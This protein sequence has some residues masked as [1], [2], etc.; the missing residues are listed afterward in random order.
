MALIGQIVEPLVE[1]DIA[2]PA[3]IKLLSMFVDDFAQCRMSLAIANSHRL[4][5]LA[6]QV[7]PDSH[8]GIHEQAIV[9]L[10]VVRQGQRDRVAA[11]FENLHMQ[12]AI[13]DYTGSKTAVQAIEFGQQ[14]EQPQVVAFVKRHEAHEAA[15]LRDRLWNQVR[16]KQHAVTIAV[17]EPENQG[18]T[19]RSTPVL[20]RMRLE[21]SSIEKLVVFTFGI[22]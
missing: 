16:I 11:A 18:R 21:I 2:T 7:C 14:P 8:I 1:H 5:K 9:H 10:Q 4:G 12:I 3:S 17:T 15:R 13:P 22:P 20:S 6:V 19:R